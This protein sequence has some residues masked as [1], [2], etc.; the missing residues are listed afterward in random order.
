MICGFAKKY[1]YPN[2][3]RALEDIESWRVLNNSTKLPKRAYRCFA[4]RG[5]HTTSKPFKPSKYLCYY[6]RFSLPRVGKFKFKNHREASRAAWEVG[7]EDEPQRCKGCK[8]L[9]FHPELEP[10]TSKLAE[11]APEEAV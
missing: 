10:I 9:H 3:D 4:C 5:W 1:S 2:L 11:K 6:G 8:E 7:R